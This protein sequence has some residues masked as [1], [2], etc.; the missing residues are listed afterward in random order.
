MKAEIISEINNTVDALQNGLFALSQ[1][2]HD[3]PELGFHEFKTVKKIKNYLQ[4]QDVKVQDNF[5][6]LPTA[7][8][9]TFAQGKPKF[10]FAVLAEFDALPEIGHGCGHNIIATAAIGTFL[11]CRQTM[12]KFGING[13]VSLIGS[14]AEEGGG[15]K[16]KLL[17]RGAFKDIDAS[18]MVH[19][20]SGTTRIAGRCT[21]TYDL[22]IEYIGQAAHAAS[23][24]FKGHNALDAA[25]LFFV[26]I[27]LLRQ[28]LTSDVRL[29]GIITEGGNVTNIIPDHTKISFSL[30][31]MEEAELKD[32]IQKV[33]NCAQGAALATGCE[34]NI[35]EEAGYG[36]RVYNQTLGNIC[37]VALE[38]LGEPVLPGFPDDFGSTDFGNISQ[39]MPTTNPYFSL[40]KTRMSLH[41]AEYEK[42]SGTQ[43]A[44][45]AI[46][47][48]SKAMARTIIECLSDEDLMEQVLK[49]KNTV[50][51]VNK[52]PR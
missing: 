14:P 10:H 5:C 15:G 2:I 17:E 6:D 33:K 52:R 43:V 28:Q 47:R 25:N 8:K 30:R 12:K 24:P 46:S 7:F 11:A 40:H 18:M 45:K 41:T 21:A 9:A 34:A 51:D 36:A 26:S 44:H 49:E 39:I 20:T 22:E 37:R 3:H 32:L 4:T 13:K 27:G 16:I 29:S 1:D 38:D 31:C 35:T 50:N 23:Q 19:P 48:S 42:L